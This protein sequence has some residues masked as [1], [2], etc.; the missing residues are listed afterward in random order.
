MT[1]N[2][3]HRILV[4]MGSLMKEN[5]ER[6]IDLDAT[7]GDGDLGLTMER[8]FSAAAE[9]DASAGDDAGAHFMKAGMAM[10]K[11]A[12]STMGTLMGTGFMRG[13]K[14]IKGQTVGSLESLASFFRAFNDGIMERGKSKPGGKTIVDLLDPVATAMEQG[15]AEQDEAEVFVRRISDTVE[16]ARDAIANM[17]SQHGKAAIYRDQTIGN[18]DPG[19][20]AGALLVQGVLEALLDG[21][22]DEE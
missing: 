21:D 16:S 12:P 11:A 22:L 20:E 14:A 4:R 3:A 10:A 7:I 6:L 17:M 18:P 13:G 2:A 9:L 1:G 15:S 8:A 5:R 19:A